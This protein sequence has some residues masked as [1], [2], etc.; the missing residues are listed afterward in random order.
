ML[1][2]IFLTSEWPFS[3]YFTDSVRILT[4]S[5]YTDPYLLKIRISPCFGYF[6]AKSGCKWTIFEE[7]RAIFMWNIYIFIHPRTSRV[8]APTKCIMF[9]LI[10]LNPLLRNRLPHRPPP[11][12]ANYASSSHHHAYKSTYGY[13][14]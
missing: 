12:T 4:P 7:I 8:S 2:I 6:W 10:N 11:P 13:S 5:P 9:F 1:G 3:P 14:I